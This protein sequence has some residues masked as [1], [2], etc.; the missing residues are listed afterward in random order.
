MPGVDAHAQRGARRRRDLVRQVLCAALARGRRLGRASR[1]RSMHGST[2]CDRH[3]MPGMSRHA[4][5]GCPRQESNLRQ[6]GLGIALDFCA[7]LVTCCFGGEWPRIS[8]IS[9]T[10]GQQFAPHMA[11]RHASPWLSA[12]ACRSVPLNGGNAC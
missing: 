11:P 10:G 3:G 1:D 2:T 6:H 7:W 12:C 8:G 9:E 5:H 4:R